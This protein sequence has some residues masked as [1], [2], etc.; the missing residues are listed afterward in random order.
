MKPIYLDYNATTP[1]DPSVVS[2]MLPFF[3]ETF[4]NPANTLNSYGWAAE[5]AIKKSAEQVANLV[6][7]KPSEIIWNAG[8]TE[9]NNS[10][11]FGLIRSLK[12]KNPKERIHFLT[13]NAEHLS[14]INSYL[15]AQRIENID[16][17]FM[18]VDTFGRVELTTLKKFIRPTTKLVSLMWV[19]N[20]IGSVNPIHELATYC[21][22]QQIFFHTDAT[23]AVGKIEIDLQKTPVHFLTFSAHKFYG[24]KGIGCLL[25]KSSTQH[26]QIEPLLFGGGQQNNHR[27]GTMNVPAIVGVGKA[28]EI[29]FDTQ[30]IE[31]SRTEALC[32]DLFGKLKEMVPTINLNG[33]GFPNRS[34]INLSLTFNKPVDLVLNQ[35]SELAFSQGS[36]CSTAGVTSSHVLKAVGLTQAQAQNTI[37]LSVGRWT[38]PAEIQRAAEILIKVFKT[39][40]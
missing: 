15:A 12:K 25:T 18:P 21:H 5:N 16:I 37:R 34:P 10:V 39:P 38:T 30:A 26:I 8:A 17:E 27:S 20:E 11:V 32:K 6:R 13:S 36:A 31:A 29:A 28:A 33:P 40:L 7:C 24:P 3:T 2:A 22:E 19:N 23:Q 9:G 14:V 1:T 35:L 4:G